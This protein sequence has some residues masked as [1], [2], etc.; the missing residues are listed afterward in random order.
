MP[1]T[2]E[3]FIAEYPEFTDVPAPLVDRQFKHSALMLNSGVWGRW[4]TMAQ[5]LRVAH[6]LALSHDISG[7]CSEL[8]M[9]S[10]YDVGTANS[11]SASTSSL[12]VSTTVSAMLSSDDPIV[13]DFARTT[14]GMQYLNLLHTVI[15]AGLVVYSPDTSAS[16]VR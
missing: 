14:Y 9:R 6:Y 4:Y 5:G 8:G 3:D 15:P 1:Y 7:K 16:K 12:S 11:K 2:R 13:A 10:P